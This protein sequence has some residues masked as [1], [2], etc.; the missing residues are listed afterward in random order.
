M[1][2]KLKIMTEAVDQKDL[3]SQ[4]QYFDHLNI[5][6]WK[7][8]LYR[9]YYLYPRLNMHLKGKT[10]DV[11]CGLGTFL[12]S[13]KRSIGIDI[14]PYC[15]D[16]CKKNGLEA[17][18]CDSTPYPF[19]DHAFDSVIFDNV[20]EHLDD[21]GEILAEIY[22]VLR[23]DGRLIIGVPTI[24]GYMSQADHRVFYNEF[25]LKIA[26]MK[27]GFNLIKSFY[28]PVRSKYLENTMNAHC[29]Y[30]IFNKTIA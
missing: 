19:E 14:N 11:G 13:R 25:D 6:S 17:Y 26:A 24:T 4:A 12:K 18:L 22:R 30:A 21:P 29:L 28:T 15:I 7:G 20:I 10:L 2:K 9:Q 23:P 16:Y 1:T 5:T 3:D 8:R 27:Y